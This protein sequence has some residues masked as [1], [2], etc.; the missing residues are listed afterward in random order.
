MPLSFLRKGLW[1]QVHICRAHVQYGCFVTHTF[2]YCEMSWVFQELAVKECI[3][4]VC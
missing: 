2:I 3:V 4:V 1:K